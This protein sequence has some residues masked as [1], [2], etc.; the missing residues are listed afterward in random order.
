MFEETLTRDSASEENGEVTH[1]I[2]SNK[3]E[4]VYEF[5]MA[6][7]LGCNWTGTWVTQINHLKILE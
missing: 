2:E 7:V 6:F 4:R 1:D 5:T 3:K